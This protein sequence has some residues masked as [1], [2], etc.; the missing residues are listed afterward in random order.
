L[1]NLLTGLLQPTRGDAYFYGFSLVQQMDEI[2]RNIGVAPQ[3]DVLWEGTFIS[4]LL[5]FVFARCVSFFETEDVC[6]GLTASEHIQLFSAFKVNYHQFCT[7]FLK[8]LTSI[9]CAAFE[10]QSSS[11]RG[12]RSTRR[13]AS[14][15]R[16]KQSMCVAVM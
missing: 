15:R 16:Q 1:I 4:L 12:Q 8:A 9:S 14:A 11:T 13:S 2:R 6:I 5:F 7:L 3:H 10:R